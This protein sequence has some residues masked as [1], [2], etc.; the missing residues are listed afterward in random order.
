MQAQDRRRGLRPSLVAVALCASCGAQVPVGYAPADGSNDGAGRLDGKTDATADEGGGDDDSPSSDGAA[1]DSTTPQMD[2]GTDDGSA[3]AGLADVDATEAAASDAGCSVGPGADYL[4]SCTS[5][6]ISGTCLLTCASC[7]TKAQT[8]N[9]SPSVQLPCPGTMS[10]QN[11]D[12]VLTC[13]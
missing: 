12:G 2:A 8:Q 10:V 9:Q 11:N 4:A 7:T 6:S 1:Q 13:Q 3:D 5:C